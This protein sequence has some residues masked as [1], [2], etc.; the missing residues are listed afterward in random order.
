MSFLDQ[1][2]VFA[3]LAESS[4]TIKIA[5]GNGPFSHYKLERKWS[6][7]PKC[8]LFKC[9][10]DSGMWPKCKSQKA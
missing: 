2:S 10:H 7:E 6:K 9:S 8:S 1:G 5:W 4:S 3:L